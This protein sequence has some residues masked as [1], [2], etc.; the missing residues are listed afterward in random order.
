M[1]GL[2]ATVVAVRPIS[3]V[4][5]ISWIGPRPRS[6]EF[7]QLFQYIMYVCRKYCEEHPVLETYYLAELEFE[8]KYTLTVSAV[9]KPVPT[10]EIVKTTSIFYKSGGIIKSHYGN[11]NSNL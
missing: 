7:P 2:D 8:V 9:Y 1:T 4:Y 6:G 3:L 11:D 10:Q 5:N